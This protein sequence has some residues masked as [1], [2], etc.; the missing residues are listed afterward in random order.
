MEWILRFNH[1]L[2]IAFM[3]GKNKKVLGLLVS[4]DH[5][6]KKHK[7]KM[8]VVTDDGNNK[9]GGSGSRRWMMIVR[10]ARMCWQPFVAFVSF[11]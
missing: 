2:I 1:L 9:V 7:K 4:V 8:P 6:Q 11:L 10:V 3:Q 5:K